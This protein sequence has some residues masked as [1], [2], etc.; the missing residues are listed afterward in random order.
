MRVALLAL[1]L[2]TPGVALAQGHAA[3]VPL[4]LPVPAAAI[5]A[6]LGLPSA[7]PATILADAARVL[8]ASPETSGWRRPDGASLARVLATPA[9]TTDIAP[10]P[11]D[12][13]IWRDAILATPADDPHLAAAILGDRT[14]A[15]LYLGL[16]ALDDE[17]LEWLAAHRDSVRSLRK[18]PALFA[19]FGRSVHVRGGRVAVPGGFEGE[20]LWRSLAGADAAAPAGFIERLFAGNG[21]LAYLVDTV[22]HLDPGRQRF[23]LGL[24][25]S[26]AVRGGRF[27]ALRRAIDLAAPDWRVDERPFARPPLDAAVLLS[28]MRVLPDGN[29]A[30]PFHRRVWET[31]FRADALTDV[32]FE[33]VSMFDVT[34]LSALLNVD[35]AWLA[36]RILDVPYA[37]GRRRLDALLLAQRV[38]GSDTNADPA[39]VASSLRGFLSFPALVLTLEQA[40]ITSPATFAAAAAHAAKVSAIDALP[41]RRSAIAEC[42][43][44]VALIERAVRAGRF[45]AARADRL[46]V[47]LSSLEVS[48]RDGY[49]TRFSRWFRDEL[50][51]ALVPAGSGSTEDGVLA[52]I[53]G[54]DARRTPAPV[55]WEDRAYLFDPAGAELRRLRLVRERQH[56]PSLDEALAAANDEALAAVLVDI[57]YD[58]HLGDPEAAAVTSG[59]VAARHD[60]GLA[61]TTNGSA[62]AWRIPVEDF[63]RRAAWRVRGSLLGLEAALGRLTLRRTN[64]ADMPPEP[65]VGPQDR[66]TLMLTVALL[67][68]SAMSDA[69]R[70]G[71]AA[72]IGRGR[73]RVET[74]SRD[75]SAID[76]VARDA[77]LS[78]WRQRALEWMLARG[79]SSALPQFSLLE[80]FWLGS[81][82]PDAAALDAWGSAVLPLTGCLCLEMPR[83]RPWEETAGHASALLGTRAADVVLRIAETLAARKLPAGLAAPL[84][85]YVMQDVLDHARLSHPD[86]WDEFGRAAR[87]LPAERIYDYIAAL[88][89]RGPLVPVTKD[90][91]GDRNP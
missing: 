82:P 81:Q 59:N 11:L 47:S 56:G 22:A 71:I 12:P 84:A 74:L 67:N 10:L 6:A 60:F 79:G 45:D 14:A 20:S 83:P 88:T 43:A 13:A 58:L 2:L 37:I 4:P 33:H 28:T 36:G 7:E 57:V 17:T 91:K 70:D 38:F 66:Q 55:T 32:P 40:G 52:A 41:V 90:E 30:P 89:A 15:L 80:L 73:A 19:A 61:A 31:V 87:D 53:A 46:I 48:P 77:G 1:V 21:R 75:A 72:A 69:S 35:A 23:A 51:A 3:R 44:A 54:V 42:Q 34:Q 8:Y 16:S 86:D 85:G 68:P 62:A 49:G 24:H 29:L 65:K 78:E 5:A 18:Q 27:A 26:P 9:A 64:D 39:L 25:L 76:A 50:A 63:D